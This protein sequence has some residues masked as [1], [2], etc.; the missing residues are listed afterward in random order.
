MKPVAFWQ[1]WWSGD[2]DKDRKY[3]SNQI[4][5]N[6]GGISLN[7]NDYDEMAGRGPHKTEIG[8]WTEVVPLFEVTGLSG[9]SHGG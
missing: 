1:R 9:S 5:P 2:R 8:Q 7:G 4:I 6:L 3:H